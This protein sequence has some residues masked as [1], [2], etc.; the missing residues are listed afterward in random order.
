MPKKIPGKLQP[1]PAAA[2]FDNLPLAKWCKPVAG[3]FYRLHSTD[4][5]AGKPFPAVFFSQRGRTRFDPELGPGTLYIGGS[6]A[7]AMLEIFD[8]HWGPVGSPNRSI[9][10]SELDARWVS[11]IALPETMVFETEGLS[12][13]KI[14]TDLQLLSGGHMAAREWAFRLGAHPA[15]IGGIAYVSRHDHT[16]RNL[17]V[18]RRPHLFPEVSDEALLPQVLWHREEKHGN[19]LVYGPAVKLRRHPELMAVLSELEVGILP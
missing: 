6:L 3:I 14:G 12:L 9:T 16:R 13:S 18:F 2:E 19:G 15:T 4:T 7:G 5:K 10:Q 8:D 1:P 11:L 17:A